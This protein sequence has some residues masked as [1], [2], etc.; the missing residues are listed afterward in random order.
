MGKHSTA[1]NNNVLFPYDDISNPILTLSNK[2]LLR[3]AA[4]GVSVSLMLFL[5]YGSYVHG[6]L[7]YR[8]RQN[9]S[10]SPGC[11][12]TVGMLGAAPQY[13]S[14]R[15]LSLDNKLVVLVFQAFT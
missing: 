3:G 1:E 5:C 11:R 14:G 8:Q 7:I 9:R 4:A 13:T 6:E 2:H 10:C 15:V 12:D